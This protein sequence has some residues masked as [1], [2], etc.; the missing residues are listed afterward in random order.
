MDPEQVVLAFVDAWNRL[1]EERIYGLM[2]DD[3]F[4][5]NIPLKPVQGRDAVRDHLAKWPVDESEWQVLN[6]ATNWAAT[7][8][9]MP[10][11]LVRRSYKAAAPG[12]RANS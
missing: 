12:R 11:M 10:T 8:G 7:T 3:I 2:A 5:H 9:P 4:Y 1:D 6:I